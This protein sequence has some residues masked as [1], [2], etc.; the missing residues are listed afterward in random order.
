MSHAPRRRRIVL[1]LTLAAGLGLGYAAGSAR[2]PRLEA[3]TADRWEERV[4]VSGPISIEVNKMG[5]Q[6]SQDA[7]YYL[8]YNSG[9]LLASVPS[10]RAS[11]GGTEILSEFAERDLV[12]DFDLKPGARPH[13]LMTTAN[14]G[15]RSEGWAPLFVF[16]TES[17]QVATYRVVP[18]AVQ[19][20]NPARPQFLLLERRKDPRLAKAVAAA[21]DGD[22]A[23]S[24]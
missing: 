18:Q 17:G 5:A 11:Q 13:F 4:L 3:D 6:V 14:L 19:G 7:L 20:T 8:N 15:L 1:A 2:V 9:R 21:A 10:V 24:R 22:S 12:R 16:E 23:A